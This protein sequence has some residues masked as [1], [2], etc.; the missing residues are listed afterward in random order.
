M[1]PNEALHETLEHHEMAAFGAAGIAVALAVWRL[2]GRFNL[3][4]GALRWVYLSLLAAACVCVGLAGHVGGQ[5][6]YVYG[7]GTP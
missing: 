1:M 5:L 2:A 4:G 3:P 7:V 6:V